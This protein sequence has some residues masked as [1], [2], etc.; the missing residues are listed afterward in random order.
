M[1]YKK[2]KTFFEI[3][4]I[5]SNY[6]DIKEFDVKKNNLQM[7]RSVANVYKFIKLPHIAKFS[8]KVS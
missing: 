6:R 3:F 4:T 8:L 2:Y 7:C 1:K 5:E